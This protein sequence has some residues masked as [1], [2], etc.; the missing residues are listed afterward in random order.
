MF[1]T[2]PFLV[3]ICCNNG[4]VNPFR[5]HYTV[6][7]KRLA[8]DVV[9]PCFILLLI[10]TSSSEVNYTTWRAISQCDSCNYGSVT[11]YQSVYSCVALKCERLKS[12][13]C[14]SCRRH[15][16]HCWCCCTLLHCSVFCCT[17]LY[18]IVLFVLCCITLCFIALYSSAFA[19]VTLHFSGDK[20][21]I[22]KFLCTRHSNNDGK[23]IRNVCQRRWARDLSVSK[24]VFTNALP[25]EGTGAF[26][27]IDIW[28]GDWGWSVQGTKMIQC[29]D[30]SEIWRNRNEEVVKYIRVSW[31]QD[32]CLAY[33]QLIGSE[34]GMEK[35]LIKKTAK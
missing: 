27:Y 23:I 12:R 6:P 3:R 25:M 32:F 11:Q 35:T 10:S 13:W 29:W 2:S 20:I 24:S 31:T 5:I 17:V 16:G 14:C 26:L 28:D 34:N 18:C 4:D 33:M 30:L 21:K 9:F 22:K 19:D 1:G 8:L 15:C 7:R